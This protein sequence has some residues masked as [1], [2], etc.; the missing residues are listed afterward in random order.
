MGMQIVDLRG[1]ER[2]PGSVKEMVTPEA[3]AEAA[4]EL[5][6]LSFWKTQGDS[7]QSL[8]GNG[9]SDHHGEAVRLDAAQSGA[10]LL[11]RKVRDPFVKSAH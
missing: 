8:L 5:R 1:F 3:A 10:W 11:I 2:E 9:G 4:V 7:M 6:P